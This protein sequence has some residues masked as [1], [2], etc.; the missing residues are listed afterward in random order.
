MHDDLPANYLAILT[1]GK[2]SRMHGV[3]KGA[4]VTRDDNDRAIT[5]VERTLRLAEALKLVPVFVGSPKDQDALKQYDVKVIDDDP[6][7]QGPLS[8]LAA[9]CAGLDRPFV[10]VGCDMPYL[11]ATVIEKFIA[12]TKEPI[13]ATR[14]SLSEPWQPLCA[15]YVPRPVWEAIQSMVMTQESLSFQ[16]LFRRVPVCERALTDEEHKTL[17]DW[18]EPK[19]YAR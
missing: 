10:L 5:I 14:R 6:S 3:F 9:C 15:R 12:P 1:G 8:G 7:M 19:D 17:G 18:D 4:L 11:S 13:T 16:R 2:A